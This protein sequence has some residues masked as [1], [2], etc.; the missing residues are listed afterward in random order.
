MD[1]LKGFVI[2]IF[3]KMSKDDKFPGWEGVAEVRKV[4]HQ[5]YV[6]PHTAFELQEWGTN[7]DLSV[8]DYLPTMNLV[9][10][11]GPWCRQQCSNKLAT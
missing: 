2:G 4:E 9:P 6:H 1:T 10:S 5:T 8:T 11:F 7:K 3:I